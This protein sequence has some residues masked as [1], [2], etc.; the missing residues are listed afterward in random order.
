MIQNFVVQFQKGFHSV[1]LNKEL[2]YNLIWQLRKSAYFC[3]PIPFNV[4][5]FLY[6]S[7]TSSLHYY[8]ITLC[9]SVCHQIIYCIQLIAHQQQRKGGE[10]SP[11]C[12]PDSTSGLYTSFQQISQDT[13]NRYILRLC[14]VY[15]IVNTFPL[16]VVNFYTSKGGFTL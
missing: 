7:H 14:F 1:H 4:L 9:S 13:T 16:F 15:V 12:Y 3:I 2:H 6:D 5:C 8:Q 10:M 11:V